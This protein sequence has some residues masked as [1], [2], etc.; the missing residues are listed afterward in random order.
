MHRHLAIM[1]VLISALTLAA[2]GGET[3]G[4]DPKE[5]AVFSG[6]LSIQ[7]VGANAR[8][9][10]GTIRLRVSADG[11]SISELSYEMEGDVCS[12][13]GVTV[14][15]FGATLRQDPPPPIEDGTFVWSSEGLRVE[16]AFSS[17]SEAE[18]TL[19]LAVEKEVEA[20]GET[21][22]VSCD[23]GKWTWTAEA[24]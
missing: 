20:S 8:A 4:G 21:L 23:F 24:E 22:T 18:G 13:Q 19:S 10:G 2:C 7:R 16:G 12:D 3:A 6:R 14:Q 5:G 11:G 17:S 15:G 9:L 1:I